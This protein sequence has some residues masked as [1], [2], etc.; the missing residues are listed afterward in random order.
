L[1]LKKCLLWAFFVALFFSVLLAGNNKNQA[2][3]SGGE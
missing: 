1:N 3:D 2:G